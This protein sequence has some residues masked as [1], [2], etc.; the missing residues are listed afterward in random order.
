MTYSSCPD[1]APP[2]LSSEA[3]IYLCASRGGTLAR[4]FAALAELKMQHSEPFPSVL[5]VRL[6]RPQWENFD[7]RVRAALDTTELSETRCR[8]MPVGVTPS[9]SELMQT[10]TLLSLLDMLRG[11]WLVEVMRQRRL[12]TYFQPIVR[13]G[14]PQDVF[15]YECLLRGT[16][17]DG[18]LI[19]PDR[20][21]GAARATGL[22]PALD[23]VARLTAIQ[24]ASQCGLG[25]QVFIN[26]NPS[27]TSDPHQALRAIVNAAVRSGVR[28]RQLVFEVVESDR[29]Q[30]VDLLV[31]ILAGYR[32]AG[33]GVALD[34]LGA[35]YSSLNLMTRIKPDY[36]K[37][38]MDLIRNVDQDV[39]KSQVAS[40]LLE[41]AQELGVKT[42]VEGVETIGEWHWAQQHGA[43]FAQGYLFARPNA[44]PLRFDS[45][46]EIAGAEP[47]T[48]LSSDADEAEPELECATAA[49]R[50]PDGVAACGS[51]Q[52]TAAAS[53][54]RPDKA[55]AREEPI[56]LPTVLTGLA[57]A[58]PLASPVGADL[59]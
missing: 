50:R 7:V 30:N 13:C 44:R 52:P 29:I 35:G 51:R 27:S 49:E 16:Q 47:N 2:R 34:D 41:L 4:I 21:Y 39:Y 28:A 56:Y 53:R 37:L 23:R 46:G 24:N 22:L 43:D 48:K 5:A 17:H 1:P 14:Q 54:A 57:Q 3:M 58:S 26:F 55:P 32:A 59:G 31:R 33:F 6:N 36:V 42:V 8:V 40:K 19:Y 11:Q 38:D 18:Q 25:S 45:S 12:T 15:A 10:Q 9:L 20:L